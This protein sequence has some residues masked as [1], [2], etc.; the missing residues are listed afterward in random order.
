MNDES[1]LRS[2]RTKETYRLITSPTTTLRILAIVD[3]LQGEGLSVEVRAVLAQESL[4]DG[5][6]VSL[7]APDA[8]ALCVPR[9]QLG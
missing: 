7:R 4:Q 2:E 1:M 9:G 6:P 3:S 8:Q 5:R